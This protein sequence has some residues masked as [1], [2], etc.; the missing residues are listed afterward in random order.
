M[1]LYENSKQKISLSKSAIAWFSR[2][3]KVRMFGK[4]DAGGKVEDPK[5]GEEVIDKQSELDQ[6]HFFPPIVIILYAFGNRIR[7]AW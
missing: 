6:K 3:K 4:N 5:N 2:E 1:F 7:I